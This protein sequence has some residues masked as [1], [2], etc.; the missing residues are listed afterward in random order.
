[1]KAKAT[2]R[3]MAMATRVESDVKGDGDGN[4]NEG[5]GQV[6]VTAT[7]VKAMGTTVVG[8]DECDGRQQRGWGWHGDGN[9]EKDGRQVTAAATKRAPPPKNVDW[10]ILEYVDCKK[11]QFL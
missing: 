2:K 1:V 4:G 3:V 9:G 6:T 5:G 11:V 8:K 10:N 7:R